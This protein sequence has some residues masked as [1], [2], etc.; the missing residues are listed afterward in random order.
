MIASASVTENG[1]EATTA[2]TS[3]ASGTANEPKFARKC[4]TQGRFDTTKAASTNE[5]TKIA[6]ASSFRSQRS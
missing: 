1:A 5:A 2:N 6:I 4:S 3:T